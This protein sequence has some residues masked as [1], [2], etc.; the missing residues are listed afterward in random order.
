MKPTGLDI[1]HTV[2]GDDAVKTLKLLHYQTIQLC[3]GFKSYGKTLKY[4]LWLPSRRA[5]ASDDIQ[6]LVNMRYHRKSIME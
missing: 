1:V 4:R 6:H 5:D 3:D 2:I